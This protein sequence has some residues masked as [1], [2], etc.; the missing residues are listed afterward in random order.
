[1]SG[2]FTESELNPLFVLFVIYALFL[3]E[4]K[5]NNAN[6]LVTKGLVNDFQSGIARIYLLNENNR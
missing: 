3:A 2:V 5:S 1:V 4:F 6:M